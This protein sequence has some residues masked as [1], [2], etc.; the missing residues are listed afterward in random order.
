MNVF[1]RKRGEYA[2]VEVVL[3]DATSRIH[4]VNMNNSIS[5]SSLAWGVLIGS[6]FDKT[7]GGVL[8]GVAAKIEYYSP[9][10]SRFNMESPVD[11]RVN[12][13]DHKHLIGS[14]HGACLLIS[15][16]DTIRQIHTIEAGIGV[17]TKLFSRV[18]II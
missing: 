14:S 18:A 9:Q 17:T 1:L 10:S 3:P 4:D 12:I 2:M 6:N 5:W 7:T 8:E 11:G 15:C 16:L 13:Q